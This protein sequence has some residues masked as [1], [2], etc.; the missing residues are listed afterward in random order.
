MKRERILAS[1]FF[2]LLGCF[3]VFIGLRYILG[4][5]NL[6]DGGIS[7]RAI[8]GLGLLA[9]EFFGEHLGRLLISFLMLLIGVRLTYLSY[10]VFNNKKAGK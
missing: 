2:G 5:E 8:C 10:Q 1:V 6:L 3:S 7:C 4:I 9:K